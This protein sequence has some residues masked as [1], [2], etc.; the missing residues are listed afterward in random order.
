MQVSHFFSNAAELTPLPKGREQR[1][2]P[3]LKNRQYCIKSMGNW[4]HK[5]QQVK[6]WFF[7]DFCGKFFRMPAFAGMTSFRR[8]PESGVSAK[9]I[10]E[11][12]KI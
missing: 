9:Q 2:H 12:K 1:V 8:K 7:K 3:V 4:Y 10:E 6:K 5:N 11:P